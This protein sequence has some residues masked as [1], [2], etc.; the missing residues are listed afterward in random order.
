MAA[1]LTEESGDGTLSLD[2]LGSCWVMAVLGLLAVVGGVMSYVVAVFGFHWFTYRTWVFDLVV[3]GGALIAALGWYSGG[4]GWAAFSAVAIGVM[5]FVVSRVELRLKGS[6]R[7]ALSTGSELP[8]LRLRTVDNVIVTH[9]D[10]KRQAPVLLVLYRG[11]WCPSSKVQ[12]DEL[13]DE[14]DRFAA[15]GLTVYA[16]SVDS[17]EQAAAMQAHVG[18]HI[19]ILCDMPASLLDDI[20]ARDTRGAPWYDRLLFGAAKRDIA[21]PTSLVVDKD[22]RIL[23]AHRASRVDDRPHRRDWLQRL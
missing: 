19:T 15:A 3:A 4:P 8:T 23:T 17:P 22:G 14:Y 21:M 7:L 16:A 6:A 12:L 10:L 13:L 1:S 9:E 20:G 5:W 18:D 2:D 11:W